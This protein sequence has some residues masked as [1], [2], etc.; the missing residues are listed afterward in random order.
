MKRTRKHFTTAEKMTSLRRHLI[1]RFAV[2][3]AV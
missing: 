3:T 2:S 1:D